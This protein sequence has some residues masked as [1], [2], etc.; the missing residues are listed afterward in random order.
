MTATSLRRR[1]LLAAMKAVLTGAILVLMMPGAG[2]AQQPPQE[3]DGLV[4]VKNKSI[5]HV[6]VR[7]NVEFKAYKRVLIAPVHVAMDK[8]W[9]PNS[10]QIGLQG[11]LSSADVQRIREE[12]AKMFR[13][14]FAD[15]LSKAGY[16]VV[17][18]SGDDVLLVEPA[19]I[20]V[21]ITAPNSSSGATRS[22]TMDAGR[23]TL[24][25]QLADSVT[26]QMLA[27]V[28][29]TT[30]GLNT[31]GMQWSTSL[32]NSAEARKAVGQW[33]DALRKALDKINGKTDGK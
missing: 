29:D 30:E 16:P 26:A 24:V 18:T 13:D 11:G 20:N 3:W 15:H 12:L 7:P 14:V 9:D 33:A 8:N 19:L 25:M 31:Q 27:R 1:A 4:R 32:A 10:G 6:Y 2:M 21:Y 17:E 5:D 22:Y 23:M 28:V